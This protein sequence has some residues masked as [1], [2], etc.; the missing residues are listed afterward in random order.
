M[1]QALSFYL[2]DLQSIL[3]DYNFAFYTRNQQIRWINE[4]RRDCARLT[5]CIQRFC[6]GWSAF[7]ASAQAGNMIAGGIQPGAL[8]GAVPLAQNTLGPLLTAQNGLQTIVGLERYPYQGFINPFVAAQHAGIK[9]VIDVVQFNLNWG[10]NFKPA[11]IWW[12]FDDLQAYCRSYANQTTSYPSVWSVFNDG[13]RGEIW[14]FPVPSQP[15]EMEL[16]ATCVP[17]DLYSDDDFDAIPEELHSAIKFKAAQL[18]FLQS[19]RYAQADAMEQMYM[20]SC[21]IS[22]VARDRGKTSSYYSRVL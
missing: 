17:S 20:T 15:N 1:A 19:Q 6:S 14:V 9:G 16:Y 18:S 3:H 13:E 4:A 12:P 2:Q 11:L 21:G 5:A 10:G 8:P 22:T 7:G